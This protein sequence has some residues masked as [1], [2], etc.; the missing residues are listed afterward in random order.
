VRTIGDASKLS[1]E[2]VKILLIVVITFLEDAQGIVRTSSVRLFNWWDVVQCCC[3]CRRNSSGIK[4]KPPL[5]V[6]VRDTFTR[7]SGLDQPGSDALD[8]AL[9]WSKSIDYLLSRPVFAIILRFRVGSITLLAAILKAF[10]VSRC[11]RQ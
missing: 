10:I 11:A 4:S 1:K 9:P 5:V 6:K 2:E 3:T 8:G 7:E